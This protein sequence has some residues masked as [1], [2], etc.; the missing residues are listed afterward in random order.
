M[1][2]SAFY[3][4]FKLR[5]TM[6]W[7]IG[8]TEHKFSFRSTEFLKTLDIRGN[9]FNF[10]DIG[11]FLE[12]QLHPQKLTFID[13]RGAPWAHFTEHQIVTSGMPGIEN[14]FSKYNITYVVTKAADSS[15]MV[16]PLVNYL[17]SRSEWEL[18]FADG[19]SLVF[20]KNSPENRHIVEKYKIPKGILNNHI[21]A[22]LIHYTYLGVSKP[23]VYSTVANFYRQVNDPVNEKRYAE[24]VREASQ[25]PWIVQAMDWVYSGR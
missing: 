6:E 4:Y 14:V 7:G 17:A 22:E 11:G 18:V 19:L 12:W 21:V 1:G 9:M 16:L 8:I 5:D 13:G 20:V 25:S 23:Y 10:F 24:Y 15:G 3:Q 2:T